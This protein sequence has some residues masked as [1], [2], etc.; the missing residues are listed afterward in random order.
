M[1]SVTWSMALLLVTA[2]LAPIAAGGAARRLAREAIAT[3][4]ASGDLARDLH[5]RTA[6]LGTS[7]TELSR[8]LDALVERGRGR[9]E[10]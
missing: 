5:R 2:T 10:G 1:P 4:G 6:G 9:S 8:S 3:R 7:T